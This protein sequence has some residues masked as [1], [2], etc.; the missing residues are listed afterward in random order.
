MIA[1]VEYIHELLPFAVHHASDKHYTKYIPVIYESLLPELFNPAVQ[2]K[3][4]NVIIR[5]MECLET[6]PI[7]TLPAQSIPSNIL[8]LCVESGMLH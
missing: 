8:S 2:M 4:T 7:E 6:R 5:M 1:A 3:V